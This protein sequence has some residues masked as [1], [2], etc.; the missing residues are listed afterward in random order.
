MANLSK[1]K[2][3]IRTL[4]EQRKN[5]RLRTAQD[6]A[7]DTEQEAA[8][9]T[10]QEAANPEIVDADEEESD[11]ESDGE[12]IEIPAINIPE[13]ELVDVK[14]RVSDTV[15]IAWQRGPQPHRQTLWRHKKEANELQLA[16]RGS[17]DIRTFFARPAPSAPAAEPVASEPIDPEEGPALVPRS[18]LEIQQDALADINRALKSRRRVLVG[19]TRGRYEAV[20]LFLSRQVKCG[21]KNKKINRMR[22]A[23]EV[24]ESVQRGSRFSRYLI[25]WEREWIAHRTIPEGRRGMHSKVMSIFNDEDVSTFVSNFVRETGEKVTAPL[26]AR[27]VTEFLGSESAGNQVQALLEDTTEPSVREDEDEVA[28]EVAEAS[29]TP[30][31]AETTQNR[32]RSIKVEAARR[33]LHR[34]GYSWRHAKKDVYVDG[35]ERPDVVAARKV[36]VDKFLTLEP[37]FARWTEEGE[38]MQSVLPEGEREIVAVT[39]DEST[40]HT[41][42]GRRDMWLQDGKNPIRPKTMGKGIMVSDFLTPASR[43]RYQEGGVTYHA[44]HLLEYGPDNYWTG[45]KMANHVLSGMLPLFEKAYPTQTYQGLFIF[46]NATNHCVTADDALIAK[47]MNLGPGGKQPIMRDGW[48]GEPRTPQQMWEWRDGPTGRTK[49]AKGIKKVLQERNLWPTDRP[50]SLRCKTGQEHAADSSC[51]AVKL[52]AAQPDFLAQKGLLQERLEARGHLVMFLPKFHPELN[53]I[54]LY[55][56]A[57]KRK[58]REECDYSLKGLRRTV[59]LALS[60]VS[61]STIRRFYEKCRR[62]ML[63]YRDGL[64]FGSLEYQERVYKS[65]RRLLAQEAEDEAAP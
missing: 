5:K 56:G 44:T 39:H 26:L 64:A 46:D 65:H 33:W 10:E 19:Q 60:S 7:Q 45:E 54:E 1:R 22:M 12:D 38:L 24:A 20:Q 42:D 61:D 17:S 62:V 16:A 63:A 34:L 15:K 31:A 58:A 57:A 40:F 32:K 49:I 28:D 3:H 25:A 41:N 37:R 13:P 14:D 18:R 30:A 11:L 8:Q 48:Y 50:F 23:L 35:H 36:F 27:A 4:A 2:R 6:T 21:L 52:M 43:L 53:W 47:K 59:P 51:C 29:N 9:G 55:W